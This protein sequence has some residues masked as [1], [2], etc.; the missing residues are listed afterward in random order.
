MEI[1]IDNLIKKRLCLPYSVSLED[2]I[3][4]QYKSIIKNDISHIACI[5][6]KKGKK[7][8]ILSIGYNNH[9]NL[10]I[11][12]STH[13]EKDAI[14]NIKLQ[15]GYTKKVNLLV[16]RTSPTGRIGCS[17]PCIKCLIDLNRL[18]IKKNI[19]IKDIYYSN[20]LGNI[21]CK[22]L[23]ELIND[24]NYHISQFYVNNKFEYKKYIK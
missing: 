3:N 21:I 1:L 19:I 8:K 15:N 17:K 2:V 18:P 11:K 13:A 7:I 22:S 23:Y 4:G 5:F 20:E 12:S 16:I 6:T 14:D 9:N 10:R 24:D